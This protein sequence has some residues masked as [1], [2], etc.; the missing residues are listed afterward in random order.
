MT[1]AE[2]RR[3]ARD[4]ET[5]LDWANAAVFWS[6]AVQNYPRQGGQLAKLDIDEMAARYLSCLQMAELRGS[7]ARKVARGGSAV[8]GEAIHKRR[9]EGLPHAKAAVVGLHDVAKPVIFSVLTTIVAFSPLLFVPGTMGKFFRNIPTVVIAVL[10]I[11]LIESLLVLPAHLAHKNPIAT[12]VRRGM[13]WVY[14][15]YAPKD[16]PL[17]QLERQARL[18]KRGLWADDGAVPPWLWRESESPCEMH[19]LA[20]SLV[21]PPS[22]SLSAQGQHVLAPDVAWYNPP[23]EGADTKGRKTTVSA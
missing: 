8:V 19:R 13:A 23:T 15:K 1:T 2:A 22:A 11:S 10:M 16:S 3:R 5:A 20:V 18:S 12:F 21:F 14:V 6:I 17:Y 9:Q 7:M 4:F